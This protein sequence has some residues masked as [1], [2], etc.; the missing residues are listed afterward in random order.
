MLSERPLI[1]LNALK[2]GTSIANGCTEPIA[3][4][5]ASAICAKV[6][7]H[8]VVDKLSVSVSAN[9]M[10]NAMAVIVPG[11]GES[12]INIAALVGY[13]F[14]DSER[15]MEVIPKLNKHDI[16]T[17]KEAKNRISVM[18]QR[19]NV[20]DK[21]Y[22]HVIATTRGGNRAEVYIAA[23]HTN[24]Y[25]I[26][27]NNKEIFS[28]PR[29]SQSAKPE[30]EIALNSVTLADLWDFA[31][32]VDLNK[33]NYLEKAAEYNIKLAAEGLTNPYGMRI[34]QI[35]KQEADNNSSIDDQIIYETAAA[36]DARMGGAPIPAATISGS[37]NQG[38]AVTV[39]LV[40]MARHLGKR[41]E[42]L[43]RSL[44]LSYL[45]A[46]YIHSF[47]PIL[48]AYCV[49]HSATMGAAAGLCY[50]MGDSLDT[51]GRAIKSMVGDATGMIC[52]GAGCSC[53]L[54]VT[55]AISGM[56][57]AVKLAQNGIT[58]PASNGIVSEGVDE[59]IRNLGQLTKKGIVKSDPA[60]LNIMVN[61]RA[62]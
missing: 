22:V 17:L 54:K 4:A 24:V 58:V 31:S 62:D 49:P 27:H 33:V 44:V 61:K 38:I 23:G 16:Y 34:G 42:D 14:G 29:P 51:A 59:T 15:K 19:A 56:L 43:V 7:N 50:L 47:Q 18:I 3:I 26:V 53:S 2:Q 57:R 8:E 40:L 21:L 46:M 30:W 55:T 6:L 60:I 9:I 37:G 11:T 10:K 52:D 28:R 12:G 35:M 36:V 39:P 20:P 48:S 41:K 13:L 5:Y 25:S 1:L 32:T 45:T